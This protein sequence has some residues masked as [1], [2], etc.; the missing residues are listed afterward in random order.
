MLGGIAGGRLTPLF[1][2][3]V[4]ADDVAHS[5]PDPET[6]ALAAERLGVAPGDCLAVEDTATGLAS[7]RDAG[8]RTLGVTNTC[9]A[10]QLSAADRVVASLAD[11]DL[12][13]LRTW[14][15]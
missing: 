1:R 15:A 7:A 10:D 9:T 8:M 3:I 11:V 5:K 13:T 4:T 12:S 14:Y 2:T 6:Y